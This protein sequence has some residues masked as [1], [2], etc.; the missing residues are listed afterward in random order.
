MWFL[1]EEV[2][3]SEVA[4]SLDQV[5]SVRMELAAHLAFCK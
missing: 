5:L 1:V 2:P 4:I 3:E